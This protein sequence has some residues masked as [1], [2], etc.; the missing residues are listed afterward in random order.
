M[1]T[2]YITDLLVQK[3]HQ[4]NCPGYTCSISYNPC[5]LCGDNT[6]YDMVNVCDACYSK[7]ADI[8]EEIVS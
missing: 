7:F 8:F 5:K 4:I 6:S 1:N 2:Q 3:R